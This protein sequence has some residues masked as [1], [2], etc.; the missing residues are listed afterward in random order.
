MTTIVIPVFNR[1]DLTRTCL[2]TLRKTARAAHVVVVDNASTDETPIRLA[3]AKWN[4]VQYTRLGRNRGF[5]TACNRGL[6]L[7]T[8]DTIVFLNNDTRTRT[9]WLMPL[10][11]RLRDPSVGAVG[12]LLLYP[13][14]RVQ[15]AGMA[16][17]GPQQPGHLYRLFDRWQHPGIMRPKSLQ[18]VT[19]A[20]LA[21]RTA[22]ARRLEGF[23]TRYLNSFEDVDLCFRV[24]A[25]LGLTVIYEPNSCLIH[26]EG[27]TEGRQ[28]HEAESGAKFFARWGDFVRVDAEQI[29]AADNAY[30]R[31]VM[32]SRSG[33]DPSSMLA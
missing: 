13:D 24:R 32:L 5:A 26:L 25:E 1:W 21:L 10:L 4:H 31:A 15:H 7:V 6:E 8:S 3:S 2:E 29:L 16:F 17:W 20:C 11:G 30:A 28:D 18:C 23:D 27:Q 12:S 14:N 22:D 33:T 9:G 19:G